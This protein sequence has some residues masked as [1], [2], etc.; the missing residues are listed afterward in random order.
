MILYVVYSVLGPLLFSIYI[1]DFSNSFDLFHFHLFVD[2]SN[3]F[4]PD[5]KLWSLQLHLS[6]QLINVHDWLCANKLPLNVDKSHFVTFHPVQKKL[7]YKVCLY[8]N[9]EILTQKC[10]LKYVG[11]IIDSNLSWKHIN[12]LCKK[13]SC[14]IEILLKFGNFVIYI[15]IHIYYFIIYPSLIYGAIVRGNTNKTNFL[16]LTLLQKKAIRII[17]FAPPT[18]HSFLFKELNL[19]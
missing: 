11:V 4:Y 9:N 7:N 12:K 14:G 6:Q 18:M 3:L 17:T 13:V 2:D 1:N 16:P 10:S 8:I 5:K 15:L 19:L